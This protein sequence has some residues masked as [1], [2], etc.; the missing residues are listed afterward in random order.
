VFRHPATPRRLHA[1]RDDGLSRNVSY[2][3]FLDAVGVG[4]RGLIE[5][6]EIRPAHSRGLQFPEHDVRAE[7]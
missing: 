5:G 4:V 2:V 7:V 3:S 1:G 6:H